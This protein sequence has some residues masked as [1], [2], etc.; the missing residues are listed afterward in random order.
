MRTEGL[1]VRLQGHY[2]VSLGTYPRAAR[3]QI[4]VPSSGVP[5][6]S[7]MSSGFGYASWPCQPPGGIVSDTPLDSAS[8]LNSRPEGVPLRP[9]A[10]TDR[11]LAL[12]VRPLGKTGT[13]HHQRHGLQKDTR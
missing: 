13:V 4:L 5:Q 8:T 2:S 6:V 1:P 12:R 3:L 7:L 10:V 9:L 11:L